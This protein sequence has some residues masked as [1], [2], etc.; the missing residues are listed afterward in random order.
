MR[1][2]GATSDIGADG[3]LP[4]YVIAGVSFLLGAAALL[5]LKPQVPR[6]EAGKTVEAFWADPNVTPKALLFWFIL[7]GASV[8]AA[9]AYFLGAGP[10]AAI[11]LVANVALFWMNGPGVFTDE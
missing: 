8:M 3:Q 11:L 1:E 5:I 6:R 2:S 4:A 7:E 10:I 9:L